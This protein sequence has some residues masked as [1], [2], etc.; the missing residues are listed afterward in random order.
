MRVAVLRRRHLW[1]RSWTDATFWALFALVAVIGCANAANYPPGNG[2]DAGDHME[3]ADG[4]IPGWHLPHGVGEYY[5]PPG[6]YFLAGIV[7]WLA[8]QAGLGDPHRATQAL[9]V[10]LLLG[11]LLLV[12]Q[13]AREL[14]PRRSRIELGAVAFVAFVPVTVKT[15]AMFHP[16]VLSMFLATL[17]LWLCVRTFADPRWAWALGVS[18]G[19]VQLVRAWGVMTVVAILL[20]LVAGRRWK[21]L[22]IALVL[23]AAIAAP[24]YIHQRAEYGG[25]PTFAGRPTVEEPLWRRRPVGFYLDPGVPDVITRPWRPHVNNLAIPTTFAEIWGDYFGVWSWKG[26][27]PPED[28]HGDLQL[29]SVIGLLPTL[30]AVAGWLMLL[31]RSLRSPPRL[32]IALVPLLVTLAYVFFTVSYPVGDGDVLK[33]TYMLTAV[34]GWAFGF[35]YALERLRGN[36]F[37]LVVTLLGLSAIVQLPFLFY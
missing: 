19:A 17:A 29:Q 23:G 31:F 22:A 8:E 14:W 18:L 30:V 15:T 3:Y 12:R 37:T 20:A 6:F 9:N 16:E 10:L 4:L 25:Q 13:I 2:Y 27:E 11:T 7:D 28:V 33:G 36:W 34:A 32:A 35:A 21:E 26:D 1:P 5:T 24:W